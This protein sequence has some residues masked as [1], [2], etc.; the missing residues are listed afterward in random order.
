VARERDAVIHPFQAEITVFR[1]HRGWLVHY[2]AREYGPYPFRSTAVQAAIEA[3]QL[4]IS[5][6][7]TAH[8][9]EMVRPAHS[10]ILWPSGHF[11]RPATAI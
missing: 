4:A 11:L 1:D 3:A 8:V 7:H 5:F 9:C 6:G 10:R 2:D